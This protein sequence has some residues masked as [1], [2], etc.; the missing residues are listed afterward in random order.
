MIL[1]EQELKVLALPKLTLVRATL[2]YREEMLDW[3][4]IAL[5]SALVNLLQYLLR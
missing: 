5:W 3:R 4:T 1:T 2:G